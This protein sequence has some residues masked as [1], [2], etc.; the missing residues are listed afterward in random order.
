MPYLIL[1]TIHQSS[2]DVTDITHLPTEYSVKI[3]LIEN[4]L[5]QNCNFIKI[6]HQALRATRHSKH[7]S[8][9][10]N[11]NHVHIPLSIRPTLTYF[12]TQKT[13]IFVHYIEKGGLH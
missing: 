7:E 13:I 1:N 9:P 4:I 3:R 12:V 8:N 6:N 10:A 5:G 11:K 2:Y